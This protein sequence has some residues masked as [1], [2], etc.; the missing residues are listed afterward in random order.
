MGRLQGEEKIDD[1]AHHNPGRYITGK[2]LKDTQLIDGHKKLMAEILKNAAMIKILYRYPH[3]P[4]P[5]DTSLAS[6]FAE[7][8][9]VSN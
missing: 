4:H 2:F 3:T 1:F 5:P 6:L 9:V 7:I 8:F